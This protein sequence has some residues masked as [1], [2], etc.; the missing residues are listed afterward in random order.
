M[1]RINTNVP[2]I[3]AQSNLQK[4]QQEL[5]LRLQ[6]L[7]TGLR[8]NRG[9]DDPAG[10]IISERIR[11]EINGAM[12]AVKNGDRASSVISTTEAALAEVSDLLNSIRGLIVES[13]NTGGNSPD[14]RAA[15]QLQIDSAIESITRISNTAS[16]GG[17]KLLNG[18]LAYRLSGVSGSAVSK[19]QV[20]N[21]SFVGNASLQVEIDVVGSAQRG[22]LF[23]RGDTTPPGVIIS[24]VT[25][26]VAGSR[27][28]EVISLPQSA[29]M[30][31]LI[32]AV[33]RLTALTGVT[34][35]AVNISSISGIVFRSEHYGSDSF[36]SVRRLNKPS[37]PSDD[38]FSDRVRKFPNT[39]QHPTTPT[40]DGMLVGDRD[41]GRDVAALIN[42]N[43]ATGR[44]LRV[45]VNSTAL[46]LDLLLTSAAAID[47]GAARQSFYITGG[48]A[49]FQ[50]GPSV[51]ALQQANLGI[52][53]MAASKLGG[54]LVN[55]VVQFLSSLK[56]GGDN[57]IDASVQR[58]D[59]SPA[60]DILNS[61][62]DEVSLLRGRLGAF[63]KNVLETNSRSLQTALENLTA[64]DSRIRD[65]DFAVETSRLT[66]AQILAAA[67]T[68]VLSLANQQA[69]NVLQLLG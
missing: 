64:S 45:S 28:V 4:T 47:P 61:A 33:N 8:I 53:S 57:S 60:S 9:S 15:N 68:S 46:G 5:A 30:L 41:E 16:F 21:A 50:L 43:L 2:S 1:A 62:I 23:Y 10:L 20:Y 6:R 27:G 48:G 3:V 26:E 67:G 36:V 38:F 37:N 11:S 51:T 31:N 69:Q 32:D 56:S 65:A 25:L 35:E 34:A 29:T 42:G 58:G 14:E 59:F 54:S 7:S 39:Y 52:P 24:A 66:R 12:T 13:A 44:G 22:E 17:L 55:G 49:M 18:G 40:W 63:E 19:T